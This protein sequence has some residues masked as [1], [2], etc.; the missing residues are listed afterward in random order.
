M[1]QF[2]GVDGITVPELDAELIG[3]ERK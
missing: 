2:I 3:I 1:R